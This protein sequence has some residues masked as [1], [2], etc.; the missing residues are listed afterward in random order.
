MSGAQLLCGHVSDRVTPYGVPQAEASQQLGTLLPRER[1][2]QAYSKALVE[3]Y[4]H[5]PEIKR[6]VRHRQLPTAIYKVRT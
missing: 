3:R 4:K 2:K 6:I 1:K 5:M